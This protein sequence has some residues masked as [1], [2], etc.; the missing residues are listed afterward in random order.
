MMK[1]SILIAA[2][3]LFSLNITAQDAPKEEG[4]VFT[5]VKEN[6]ITSIK[7]QN[8]SST[9]WSFSSLGFLESELLRMGKGEYDLSEMFVVH[10]TM[11]DRA[12]N[13]VRYHGDSSFS[14]GGSFYDI[15]FCL[16]NY[17]LVPQEAMPGIMYGD[18]LPV[19]NEL[20]AVAGAYTNAIAKG[21]LTKLS[22]VWK[23]GLSAIYD[24]Y[25]GKC[26]EKFTYKGKEYTPQSF[27]ESLGLNMDDYVELTSFT[28]KPSYET[29]SPEVPDNWEN[30]PMYN[31]PLDELIGAIDYALNKGYT[32][33][34]DGDV[35][36]QGFS[37]K[38]G[39]AI[40]P[41]VEDV[42][43]YS[44]T[45]RARFEKMP[46]YERMDEVFKFK[47]PY[48]EINVT[49]EIRQDGYEKFVTTDDHLMHITGIVKD[50][51]GTK[52]YIT[53]NS[54]GADSN[55]SGGYLNMSESYVRAKTICVMVHKDSLPKELKKK[56][57]IQ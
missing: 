3:G 9:C 14:P 1:K 38:N 35:S 39:I 56:L 48:P 2:L 34:W 42:K 32:V 15:M 27:T 5:T 45:D 28:H 51:N 50:Q 18:T 22:P 7:N 46:K 23:N 13:Y 40:N 4:F 19:H 12:Q 20:D 37:F 24:T 31:L 52:Y 53:K 8:R 30:Q 25:L 21:K 49:P 16:K 54:W 6:P 43:D 17:G 47:H 29:F 41:Q 36:E 11:V 33:C 10:H 44:T 26:P 55:K 57:G